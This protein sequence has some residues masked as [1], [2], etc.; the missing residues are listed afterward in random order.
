MIDKNCQ[1]EP[2]TLISVQEQPSDVDYLNKKFLSVDTNVKLV[3]K[4][5]ICQYEPP[6]PISVQEQPSEV[7]YLNKNL[8]RYKR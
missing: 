5:K 7:D 1:Y 3:M 6:T 2:Q 8:C 4:D